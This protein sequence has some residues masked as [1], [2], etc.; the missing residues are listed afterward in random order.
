MHLRLVQPVASAAEAVAPLLVE[1]VRTYGAGGHDLALEALQ[2]RV[3]VVV[4][5]GGLLGKPPRGITVT[6]AA[7]RNAALFPVFHG[8]LEVVPH[9]M[10]SCAVVLDGEYT[11]PLGLLGAVADRTVLNAVAQASL[12]RFLA[13]LGEDVAGDVLRKEAGLGPS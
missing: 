2:V 11:V 12:R 3:P 10:L 9:G 5:T 4:Q 6:I 8:A 7:E 13:R 1:R